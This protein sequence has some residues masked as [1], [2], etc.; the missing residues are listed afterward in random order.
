MMKSSLTTAFDVSPI[1]TF[2]R[3]SYA[4]GVPRHMTRGKPGSREAGKPGSTGGFSDG[5]RGF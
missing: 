3:A 1:A 4:W 5:N 2:S